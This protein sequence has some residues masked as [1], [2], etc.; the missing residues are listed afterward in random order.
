MPLPEITPAQ[1]KALKLARSKLKLQTTNSH[2]DTDSEDEVHTTALPQDKNCKGGKVVQ[3]AKKT[4]QAKL[5]KLMSNKPKTAPP[6]NRVAAELGYEMEC[7]SD[8]S[9]D[10]WEDIEYVH[11]LF[12]PATD[13][14]YADYKAEAAAKKDAKNKNEKA[15]KK[16]SVKVSYKT[17][18]PWIAKMPGIK[19]RGPL[20]PYWFNTVDAGYTV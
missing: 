10:D 18:N 5:Q 4:T 14:M 3:P 17:D 16:V 19:A 13:M 20:R 15:P 1:L 6:T 12:V 11:T 9:V 8:C 2:L 7:E